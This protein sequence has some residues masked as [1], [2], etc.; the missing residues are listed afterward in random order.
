MGNGLVRCDNWEAALRA[1]VE[2]ARARPFAWGANDC[3]L[4]AAD[5]VEA[6]TGV[7]LAA[8]FRGKYAS[9]SGARRALM[10]YGEGSLEAT[11]TAILGEPVA[12]TLARRGDVVLFR[13]FPP[14]SPPEGIEA[15]AVCLGEVAA[16]P[17]PKVMTYVPMGEWLKAWR[18]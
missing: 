11:V 17:G 1:R 16:S 14:D 6:M 18:V 2:A 8:A 7:D 5:C 4:F 12:A 9:P 13:S 15:L 3:A 10:R